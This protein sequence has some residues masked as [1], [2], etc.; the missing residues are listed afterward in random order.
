VEAPHRPRLRATVPAAALNFAR[1]WL[2]ARRQ[3]GL[4]LVQPQSHERLGGPVAGA[5]VAADRTRRVE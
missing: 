4:R 5:P 2:A 1:L 3:P